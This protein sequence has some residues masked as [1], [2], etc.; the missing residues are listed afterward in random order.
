MDIINFLEKLDANLN[1]SIN[2]FNNIINKTPEIKDFKELKDQK[3]E[4][5]DIKIN[6]LV[7]KN[8]KNLMQYLNLLES[9]ETPPLN[10]DI[11][12]IFKEKI[13]ST[14]L[15]HKLKTSNYITHDSK[16][17]TEKSIDSIENINISPNILNIPII[18]NIKDIPPMFYWYNGDKFYKKGIYVS[19]CKGFY[20]KVPF[21]NVVSANDENFKTKT[22]SCKFDSKELCTL[23]KKKNSEIYNSD[24][25]ECF[26]VHKKEKFNKVGSNYRCLVENFGNHFTLNHDLNIIDNTNIKHILMYSLSD[27]LLTMLWYQNKFKNGNLVLNNLDIY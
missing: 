13:N 27:S 12:T 9:I 25:R 5:K 23:N 22:M 6:N 8:K 15:A 19:I 17:I 26:Y 7:L 21:P 1:L 18:E 16:K 10:T 20:A 11:K 24:I 14:V 3:T 2:S 4:V